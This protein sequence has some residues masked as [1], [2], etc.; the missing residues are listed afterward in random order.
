MFLALP[1]LD[2]RPLGSPARS[3]RC[4]DCAAAALHILPPLNRFFPASFKGS[5]YTEAM[6][7]LTLHQHRNRSPHFQFLFKCF[8][9]DFRLKLF[10]T[11]GSQP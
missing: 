9:E 10:V 8:T 1:G 11:S 6:S 2:L 3:R 5:I 4:T 7:L